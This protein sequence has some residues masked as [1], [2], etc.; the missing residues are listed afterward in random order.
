[1]Y[2]CVM[3]Q[4]KAAQ[5]EIPLYLVLPPAAIESLASRVASGELAV[6]VDRLLKVDVENA[7]AS[8]PDDEE[9]VKALIADTV[10]FEAVNAAVVH[11]MKKMFV[12]S[13]SQYMWAEF[14]LCSPCSSKPTES[15]DLAQVPVHC[16]G[17]CTAT[18]PCTYASMC[19]V[20]STVHSC[21]CGTVLLEQ[22][23]CVLQLQTNSSDS[24]HITMQEMSNFSTPQDDHC[25]HL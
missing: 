12:D 3:L 23:S 17:S 10:G 9:K 18:R 21:V 4:Y 24:T 8:S 16:T 13:F 2:V 1:M 6:V 22:V 15:K 11:C 20:S 7:K 5:L 19:F 14:D 25:Y